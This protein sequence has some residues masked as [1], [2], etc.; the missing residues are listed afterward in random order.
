MKRF[1]IFTT[2]F[3]C[4]SNS[5]A[6]VGIGTTTPD[7]SSSLDISSTNSGLLIPRVSLA[8]IVDTATIPLPTTSLLVYNTNSAINFG[9]GVGYYY[10][11][12]TQWEKLQT[13]A[14]GFWSRSSSGDL[15]P[16]TISDNVGINTFSP[17]SKLD[18][19]GQITIDQ[20]NFGGYGGLLI[21]GDQPGNNYPNIAFSTKNTSGVDEVA[22]YIGGSINNNNTGNEAIDLLFQTSTNGQ[23]GLTEKMRIKDNGNVG[24]NNNNPTTAKLV[25][26]GFSGQEGIDLSSSDLY[27]NLRVLRNNLSLFDNDMFI[28]Y[29]SGVTSSLHLF[30]NNSETMTIANNKVGIGTTTPTQKLDIAGKIKITD[31]FEAN[32]KVLTSDATGVGTWQP[33]GINN[34]SATLGAGVNVPFSTVNFLQT[35]TSITL[36]PGRYAVNVT[37]LLTLP[38]NAVTPANSSFW[39]RSS[40]SESSGL[41]PVSSGDIQGSSLVSGNLTGS[42]VF[43]LMNG[44]VIINNPN[45]ILSKTYYYVAGKVQVINSTGTVTSIGGNFAENNIIAYKLQ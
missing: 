32:G 30:S 34:I 7:A 45:L 10:W 24:I 9:Y 43:S 11:N 15:F 35:G 17:T 28:G 2:L 18:V 39:V 37:M 5:F 3:L 23:S 44:T 12:G 27:A 38:G 42:S 4:F 8:S 36:P 16:K 31:G 25:I 14:D 6:Q 40:F 19:N 22:A 1:Y 41:N 21:K 29:G 13:L 20:K 33:I 26:S